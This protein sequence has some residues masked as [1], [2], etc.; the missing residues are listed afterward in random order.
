M[1]I[2]SEIYNAEN[3]RGSVKAAEAQKSGR[4]A[5][6]APVR[7]FSQLADFSA[8]F[9]KLLTMPISM[10]AIFSIDCTGTYS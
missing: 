7:L 8:Y 6:F 2:P 5:Y 9:A 4:G 3:R 10:F 1:F